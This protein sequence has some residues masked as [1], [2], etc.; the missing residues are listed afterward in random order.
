MHS[1]QRAACGVMGHQGAAVNT[2][3]AA[4]PR[5]SDNSATAATTPALPT[6]AAAASSHL[7]RHRSRH[8]SSR[9]GDGGGV[10]RAEQKLAACRHQR[11]HNQCLGSIAS[12]CLCVFIER[13]HQHSTLA[14]QESR[15]S[16]SLAILSCKDAD[17][18]KA[19]GLD[20]IYGEAVRTQARQESNHC[21][22]MAVELCK[23]L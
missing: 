7:E 12:R 13:R 22:W 20:L 9:P 14:L 3:T 4:P 5:T 16:N 10:P 21:G 23:Q 11:N 15:S 6:A 2:S 1:S 8:S 19:T 18:S 17:G